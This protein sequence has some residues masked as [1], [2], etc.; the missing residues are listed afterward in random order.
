[1]PLRTSG[2]KRRGLIMVNYG[3]DFYK[4]RHSRTLYSAR[5][6]LSKALCFIPPVNSAVDLGCGV[7]T[8]LL[9]LKEMG[10]ARTL[11]MDGPWLDEKFLVIPKEDFRTT[12]LQEPVHQDERFDLALSLEVAEHIPSEFARTFV[13]SLTR[14]SD[15][16]LF[17]AAI[18]FQPGTNHVNL[19]WPKYWIELFE[20]KGYAP[21]DIRRWIWEDDRINICYRQNCLLFYSSNRAAELKRENVVGL[22]V[23]A[24]LSMVHPEMYT[25]I[26]QQMSTIKGSLSLLR[27]AL[28]RLIKPEQ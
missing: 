18:P 13:G 27:G 11:G 24:P 2:M 4:E 28:K 21:I 20:E 8:W 26:I 12:N 9:A 7:G 22:N 14:L 10:A 6:V 1:M 25:T 15:F 5:T 16:V 19:Q 3:A 17:S 23:S